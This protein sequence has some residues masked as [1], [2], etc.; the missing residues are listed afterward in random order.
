MVCERVVLGFSDSTMAYM[1]VSF[2]FKLHHSGLLVGILYGRRD[3]RI[4][5]LLKSKP[6]TLNQTLTPTLTSSLTLIPTLSDMIIGSVN[7]PDATL[8]ASIT[9]GEGWF[10][11]FFAFMF[12]ST[13]LLFNLMFVVVYG[14]YRYVIKYFSLYS[15]LYSV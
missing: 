10:I 9:S 8:P 14:D 3:H 1:I 6:A 11:I 5:Q 4:R 15:S 13:V 2:P 7:Y 12:V